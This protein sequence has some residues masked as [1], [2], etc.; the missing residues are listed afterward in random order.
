M[1]GEGQNNNNASAA[2][3]AGNVVG[4]GRQ[5]SAKGWNG[6]AG[7]QLLQMA[8]KHGLDELTSE[9]DPKWKACN[10]ELDNGRG[11]SKKRVARF[12][13]ILFSDWIFS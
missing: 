4:K 13:Y 1:S 5:A 10:A 3:A 2:P 12:G 8:K 9:Q 11:I 6:P 7:L